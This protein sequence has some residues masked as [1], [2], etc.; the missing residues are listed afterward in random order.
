MPSKISTLQILERYSQF[1]KIWAKS[2]RTVFKK[3]LLQVKMVKVLAKAHFLKRMWI[4]ASA[5]AGK[6]AKM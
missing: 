1:I 2:S 5:S 6:F 4:D 3:V